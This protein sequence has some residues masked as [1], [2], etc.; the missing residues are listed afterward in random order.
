MPSTTKS[1]IDDILDD[2]TISLNR[3]ERRVLQSIRKKNFAA[4]RKAS[5]LLVRP[6]DSPGKLG[7]FN[8]RHP[9]DHLRGWGDRGAPD[10]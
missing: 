9:P 8:S 5:S 3:F 4:T 6:G 2:P 10:V 1:A 7:N